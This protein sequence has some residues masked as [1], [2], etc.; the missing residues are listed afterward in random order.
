V[1]E[2]AN[3]KVQ[4]GCCTESAPFSGPQICNF[5][6]FG[7]V[8]TTFENFEVGRCVIVVR[9]CRR[10]DGYFL[11]IVAGNDLSD[12]ILRVLPPWGLVFVFGI[13]ER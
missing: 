2:G 4:S 13:W 12:G 1:Q 5:Q 9:G 8:G 3:C 6:N 11:G 10:T 7:L